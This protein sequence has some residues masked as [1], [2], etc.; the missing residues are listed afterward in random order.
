[1]TPNTCLSSD[2]HPP[3]S[4]CFPSK[5]QTGNPSPQPLTTRPPPTH[6]SDFVLPAGLIAPQL[7]PPGLLPPGLDERLRV[8]NSNH[9]DVEDG[10]ILSN[11][12]YVPQMDYT[13]FFTYTI[14]QRAIRELIDKEP[15]FI[16]FNELGR[17]AIRWGIELR[18][19][20][21]VEW[22]KLR[23]L[24]VRLLHEEWESAVDPLQ[25]RLGM[26]LWHFNREIDLIMTTLRDEAKLLSDNEKVYFR[27]IWREMDHWWMIRAKVGTDFELLNLYDPT[28]SHRLQCKLDIIANELQA[29]DRLESEET[30]NG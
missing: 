2:S 24:L 25:Y 22:A 9:L 23:K 19:A 26:Y 3:E 11:L 16:Q 18:L 7:P 10:I 30:A 1:M 14:T 29:Y 17:Y 8:Q 28:F 27:Y 15:I 12:L 20:A 6:Q 5:P 21:L 4:I 13:D